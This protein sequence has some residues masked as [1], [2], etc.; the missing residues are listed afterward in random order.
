MAKKEAKTLG[1]FQIRHIKKNG[2]LTVEQNGN[3]G[4]LESF[5]IE[6]LYTPVKKYFVKKYKAPIALNIHFTRA[7]VPCLDFIGDA[8]IPVNFDYEHVTDTYRKVVDIF[9]QSNYSVSSIDAFKK[10]ISPCIPYLAGDSTKIST[11]NSEY[12]Q[13]VFQLATKLYP[14]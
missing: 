3:E 14:Q 10:N 1:N 7:G 12:D 6:Q 4:E 5:I 13:A 9:T 8:R 2:T 11:H